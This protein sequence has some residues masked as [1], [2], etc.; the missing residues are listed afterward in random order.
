MGSPVYVVLSQDS[1]VKASVYRLAD[2]RHSIVISDA[3]T[4]ETMPSAKIVHSLAVAIDFAHE[5]MAE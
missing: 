5:C 4:G 1:A 2:G 3:H